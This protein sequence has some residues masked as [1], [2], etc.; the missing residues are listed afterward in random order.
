MLVHL[1]EGNKVSVSVNKIR[2]AQSAF[3]FHFPLLRDED[4][5]QKRCLDISHQVIDRV[6]LQFVK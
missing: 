3:V 2:T 5:C 4:V 1:P 6:V